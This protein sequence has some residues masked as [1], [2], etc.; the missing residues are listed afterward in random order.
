MKRTMRSA[1]PLCLIL[2]G[3]LTTVSVRAA[4]SDDPGYWPAWRGP[5]A[6]GVSPTGDPP[7]EWSETKNIKWKVELPGS[8]H[9]TPV[10]W[11]DRLYLLA[12]IPKD[13]SAEKPAAPQTAPSTPAAPAGPGPGSEQ[14]VAPSTPAP[15]GRGSARE[16]PT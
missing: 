13:G 6:T 9:S 7:V 14:P 1:L 12:A 15:T 4:A 5:L 10:V 8:G 11:G 3:L 16:K 2:S